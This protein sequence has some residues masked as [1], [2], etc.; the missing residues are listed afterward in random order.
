[1]YTYTGMRL[2]HPLDIDIIVHSAH[3]LLTLICN[4]INQPS[5]VIPFT[6]LY[7]T[8]SYYINIQVGYW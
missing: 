8:S 6:R 2:A 7:G 5:L 3:A 1:M 4:N